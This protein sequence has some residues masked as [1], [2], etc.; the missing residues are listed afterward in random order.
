MDCFGEENKMYLI[1]TNTEK[2]HYIKCD[3]VGEI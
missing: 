3:Y 2:Y 1:N